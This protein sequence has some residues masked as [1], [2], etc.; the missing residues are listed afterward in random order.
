M[1]ELH[2]HQLKAKHHSCI[3]AASEFG[4]VSCDNRANFPLQM[5]SVADMLASLSK[6]SRMLSCKYMHAELVCVL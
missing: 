5:D 1:F 6:K 4:I 3:V 2:C